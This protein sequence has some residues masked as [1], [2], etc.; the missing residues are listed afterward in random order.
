M[1]HDVDGV[2]PG[3][4]QY[5]IQSKAEHFGDFALLAGLDNPP[6]DVHQCDNG[7]EIV[8]PVGIQPFR[9]NLQR[10]AARQKLQGQVASY[11]PHGP[12]FERKGEGNWFEHEVF[13]VR[14]GR[15][16]GQRLKPPQRYTC[17]GDE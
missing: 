5:L 13:A 6:C 12:V 11:A 2:P 14:N 8:D 7:C 17:G 15:R 1:Q 9:L 4:R 10:N 16:Q 3:P